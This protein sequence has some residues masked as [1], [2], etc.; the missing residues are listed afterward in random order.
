MCIESLGEKPL[1][2]TSWASCVTNSPLHTH[3]GNVA[4]TAKI[5]FRA[6]SPALRQAAHAEQEETFHVLN[7][8]QHQRVTTYKPGTVKYQKLTVVSDLVLTGEQSKSQE[9]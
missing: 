7:S 4:F 9:D 5:L 8:S 1:P 3:R 2:L 6:L